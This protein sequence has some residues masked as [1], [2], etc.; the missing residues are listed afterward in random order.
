MK[1]VIK[2][3]IYTDSFEIASFKSIPSM[4]ADELFNEIITQGD[5]SPTL[6]A[7]FD[8]KEEAMAAWAEKYAGKSRTHFKFYN[9]RSFLL[10]DYAYMREQEYEWDEDGEEYIPAGMCLGDV[11]AFDV[12]AYDAEYDED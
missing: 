6:E 9:G 11:I 12:G 8:T 2:Y 3:E 4:S 5:D 7:S 1:N 10:G